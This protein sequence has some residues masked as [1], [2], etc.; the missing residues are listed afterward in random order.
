MIAYYDYH[1][2]YMQQIREIAAERGAPVEYIGKIQGSCIWDMYLDK[3]DK[4][5]K[6]LIKVEGA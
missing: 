5:G 2:T 6:W 1:T 3:P 4:Q